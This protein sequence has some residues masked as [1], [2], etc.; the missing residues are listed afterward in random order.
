MVVHDKHFNIVQ[1][2]T[3]RL[4]AKFHKRNE[5]KKL[6]KDR[7]FGGSEQT[8]K[9]EQWVRNEEGWLNLVLQSVL[10]S[11]ARLTLNVQS[12]FFNRFNGQFWEQQKRTL[13]FAP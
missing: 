3:K 12:S 4:K 8:L 13:A 6:W 10:A 7:S 9:L 11:D 1:P 5:R 2:K